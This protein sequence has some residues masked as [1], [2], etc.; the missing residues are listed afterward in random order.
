MPI[1]LVAS[2]SVE[3]LVWT[4]PLSALNP[5]ANSAASANTI[6]EWPR[7]KK[8]PTLRGRLP[9]DISFRVVLSIAEMWSASNA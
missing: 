6:V 8:N 7:E 3:P 4:G 1:R 9:S 2:C 5:T